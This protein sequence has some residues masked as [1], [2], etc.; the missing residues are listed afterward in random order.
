MYAHLV[1]CKSKP[2]KENEK[3]KKIK[4][5]KFNNNKKRNKNSQI[6]QPHNKINHFHG[7]NNLCHTSYII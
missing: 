7:N 1:P 2:R 6:N 3:E 5:I 4:L